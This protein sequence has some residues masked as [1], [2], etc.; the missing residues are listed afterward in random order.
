M[1]QEKS[2]S[3]RTATR[4]DAVLWNQDRA[5]GPIR[6]PISRAEE[7]V[8]DFNRIYKGLGIVLNAVEQS[9]QKKI[10]S[11]SKVAGDSDLRDQVT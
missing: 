8:A 1:T 5:L 9:L 7:F 10:P 3:N 11:N 2:S 6:L 4:C